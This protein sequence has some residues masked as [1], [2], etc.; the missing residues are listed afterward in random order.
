MAR[1]KILVDI[2]LAN[3]LGDDLFLDHLAHSFPAIEFIPFHPGKDYSSFFKNYSNI[4]QFSYSL[5]DKVLARVGSNK[6]TDYNRLSKDFDGL[7]FLGGGIFREESYW[8]E[9]YNYRSQITAAFKDKG[10]KVIF[11]GCNFGPYSTNEFLDTHA[12]LFAK[13]DRITF[14]DQKSYQLFQNLEN[15]SYSPDVIWS[16]DLPGVNKKNKTI[17]ISVIDPRHKDGY[18]HTYQNYINAHKGFCRKYV[19]I[20]YKIKLFSF[21]EKEGDLSVAEE[22]AKDFQE[23][24]IQNYNSDI[25]SYLRELGSCSHFVAVRFHA[26]IIAFKYDIPVIPVIYGDKTENLL[27]DLG[28]E[29]PFVYLDTINDLT[30]T[31]FS[32]ISSQQIELYNKESKR[33]FDFK[34]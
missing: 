15:V 23:V 4:Q 12:E 21:C 11:S 25:L 20:G 3:N 10:K 19:K 8:K 5:F 28:F 31:E 6:L 2:Y 16:Y 9:V 32:T 29:K 34:F 33:H 30:E 17:G 22:I 1:K 18:E 7:L 24:D 13:V 14:R 26:V 27:L